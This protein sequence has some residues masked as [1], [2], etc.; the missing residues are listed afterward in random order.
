MKLLL[1]SGSPRRKEL[2]SRMGYE[3]DI[4]PCDVD[5][6]F[7]DTLSPMKLLSICQIKG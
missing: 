7:N 2:L 1:A 4:M 5:E 3:F 6:S